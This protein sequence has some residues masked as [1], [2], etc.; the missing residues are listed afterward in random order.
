MKLLPLS[1]ATG[2]RLRNS[3]LA[4]GQDNLAHGLHRHS[5][6]SL[7]HAT[8]IVDNAYGWQERQGDDSPLAVLRDA[9]RILD[10]HQ[11]YEA[12]EALGVTG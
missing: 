11:R 8:E 10:G 7:D 9:V 4:I 2:L 12:L 1:E 5:I 3:L 6:R